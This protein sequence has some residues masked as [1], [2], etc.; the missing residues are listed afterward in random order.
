MFAKIYNPPTNFWCRKGNLQQV[1]FQRP[2]NI[3]RL[4]T[5]FSRGPEFVDPWKR[6]WFAVYPPPYALL[7]K[8][9]RGVNK[10]KKPVK[11]LDI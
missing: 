10:V 2:A 6:A 1:P 7:C 4:R 3:M 5:K 11:T 8:E 9:Y